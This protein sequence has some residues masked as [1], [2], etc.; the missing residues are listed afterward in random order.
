MAPLVQRPFGIVGCPEKTHEHRKWVLKAS[1]SRET[2]ETQLPSSY[3]STPVT[4][5]IRGCLFSSI[6]W[7]KSRA[8]ARWI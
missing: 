8:T 6:C 5:S 4:Q 7:I 1:V 3:V 2:L